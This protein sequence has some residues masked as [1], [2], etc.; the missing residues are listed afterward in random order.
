MHSF[1]GTGEEL[2]VY[3]ALGLHI[4]VN[5]CSLKTESNCQEAARI[6]LDRLHLET[7]APYCEIKKSHASFSLLAG[8]PAAAGIK[9][10]IKGRCEPAHITQVATVLAGLR[11]AGE[12]AVEAVAAAAHA[13]STRMFFAERRAAGA[14]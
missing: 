7:D 1:T 10:S 12:G 5:G 11:G 4:G 3:L 6:P 9:G 8:T 2:D 14:T 13:N